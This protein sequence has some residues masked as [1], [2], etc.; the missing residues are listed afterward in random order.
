MR[1]L[2]LDLSAQQPPTFDTFVTGR[3]A[4]LLQRLHDIAS[5][6]AQPT[7]ND[8]FI[9]L[10]GETGAGKTHLLHSLA[11]A[12]ADSTHRARLISPDADD[13]AF[14]YDPAV[15]CYLLDDCEQLPPASQIAAFNLFNQI[16][17]LG[18][19][20]VSA[21]AQPPALLQV[22]EDLRTRLSW[23]LIY[24]LHGLTDDEKI[25]ALMHS[26][27][28]RGMSVSP[29]ILSYLLTHYRRDMPSLSRM[30][31]AL[32]RYSLETKRSITLPLLR[33]LLQQEADNETP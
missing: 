6:N 20:L 12:G 15:R 33:D 11:H 31:D 9:Y 29:A 5:A 17:E 18:G 24:Q 10:W 25:A 8:R 7:L 16:R 14:D 4:E 13:S 1:Q 22:R 26:A 32:D 2:L 19:Y 21:G 23:G 27:Q 3:N 30:L 28:A